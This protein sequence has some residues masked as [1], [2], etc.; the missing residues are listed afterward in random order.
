M[1]GIGCANCK[2]SKGEREISK[3]LIEQEINFKKQ[4]TFNNCKFKRQ[5][6]FD[7][8]L[9]DYNLCIEFDG[10]QHY[11][12]IEYFGGETNLLENKKRDEFKNNFCFK[13]NIKLE[14]IKYDENIIDRLKQIKK[15]F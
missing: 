5:L 6:Y 7:F 3:W 1:V 15:S 14:R 4:K 2:E 13:N 8:Y 12:S 11:H 10:E 9:P